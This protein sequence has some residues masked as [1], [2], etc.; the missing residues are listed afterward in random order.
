MKAI[1]VTAHGSAD[2]LQLREAPIP[3]L[4]PGQIRIRLSA[5]TVNFADIQGRRGRY[6]TAPDPPF[7]PGLEAAGVIGP[8]VAGFDVGQRV[9]CHA[10]GGSYAEYVL[11]RAIEAFALPDAVSFENAACIPSVGVTAF[12]LLTSAGRMQPG[13]TVLIHAA[14]GG[15][16]ST[17]VQLARVLG[18]GMIIGTVGSAE[19]AKVARDLGTDATINY[20]E[21]NVLERV[22][23][24]TSGLGVDVVLDAVG[25][26]TFETSL[27]CL[28]P[29][30]RLVCYGQ[31]SGPPPPVACGPLY[32]ENKSIIGYSTGGNRRL[33]PDGLRAP[34][35]S[36]LKLLQQDRWKPVIGARF[37]LENAAE[38]HQL[39]EDRESIGKIILTP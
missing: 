9:F 38:A 14:A 24:L 8:G 30:G 20:R 28:A 6:P 34:A 39:I 16:G 19:K 18:A 7:I 36:V 13:E 5:T 1:F 32:A 37:S 15:V 12:N 2:V 33:R 3:E 10:V 23:A 26:D 17:A 22:R 25:A 4:G 35:L 31:S 27:A 29:F 11:A 21:E